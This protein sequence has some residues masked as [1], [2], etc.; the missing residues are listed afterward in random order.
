MEPIVGGWLVLDKPFGESSREAVNRALRW[1]PR[2][3]PVGHT[4]TLDPRAT[5]V[6]VLAVGRATRLAEYVQNLP[7]TYRARV[8]LGATSATDDGEGPITAVDGAADP[9]R[10]AV[11]AALRSFL[12][13]TLQTPPAFSAVRVG[14]RRAYREAR[15][16]RPVA[17]AAKPVTIHHIRLLN[18]AFP[19][20]DLEIVCGKGT[21]I[22]SLARDLGARLG[23]GGYVEALRRTAV[24]P[25]T[26]ERATPVDAGEPSLLPLETGLTQ[27]ARVE[28]SDPDVRRFRMGQTIVGPDGLPPG[29]VACFD[30]TGRL[31]CIARPL[32]N[33]R[34][35]PDKVLWAWTRPFDPAAGVEPATPESE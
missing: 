7:K 24:G 32:P 3:T 15:A 12:G 28:V 4:G 22:R 16:G 18:Y 27:L 34:L 1:F 30:R 5:G 2:R 31:V 19:T 23:V 25:F 14:G 11:E 9:G 17:P 33:G 8:A 29:P 21:Y 10:P 6:L 20:I 35:Q 26:P 13:E